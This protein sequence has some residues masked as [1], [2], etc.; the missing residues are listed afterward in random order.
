[1]YRDRSNVKRANPE[2]SKGFP[3][4]SMNVFKLELKKKLYKFLSP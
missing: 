3:E 2:V 4:H 1:M